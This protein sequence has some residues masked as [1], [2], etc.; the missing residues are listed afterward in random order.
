M[1]QTDGR[2]EYKWGAAQKKITV[3]MIVYAA[4]LEILEVKM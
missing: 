2:G 1:R 4:S 3:K